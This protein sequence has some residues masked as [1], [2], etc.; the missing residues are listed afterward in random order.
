MNRLLFIAALVA[1]GPAMSA[2]APAA[3]AASPYT[4]VATTPLPQMPEGDFDQL[5]ADVA[6]DRLYVSAEDGATMYVF[7][8]RTGALLRSGGAVASPHKVALDARR[9]HLFVADGSDGSVKVLDTTL[10]LIARIPVGPKADTGVLDPVRRLFYVSS[11]DPQSPDTALIVSAIS[12]DSLRVTATYRLPATTL[13]GMV[14]DAPRHRLLVS[15]RDTNTIGVV[16]LET[17]TTEVW[18]SSGLHKSVPLALDAR[19]DAL[20]AGSRSWRT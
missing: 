15:M 10:A 3:S 12:C 2:T 19:H 13:K 9:G 5:V 14:L 17:A 16:H 1:T 20:Y 8:L 18:R 4:L 6:H 7:H 11:R